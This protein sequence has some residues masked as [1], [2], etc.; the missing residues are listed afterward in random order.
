MAEDT[1]STA[2]ELLET[3]RLAAHPMR[4]AVLDILLRAEHRHLNAEQLC[5]AMLS[6][7]EGMAISSF[8]RALYALAGLGPLA[9]VVVPDGKNRLLTFY[10]LADQPPHR[11]LYC[12]A[13]A[14]LTEVFDD[15]LEQSLR[16][17]F[18][19][20]DLR[21]AQVDLALTGVCAACQVRRR[22]VAPVAPAAP[23]APA[24]SLNG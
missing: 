16:R 5:V 21:P 23:A 19:H 15:P 24:A 3:H 10:E 8:K 18:E 13:C 12:T 4:Q 20:H 14:R 2:I 17:H 7:N 6:R 9:R 1:P 22:E 11:H